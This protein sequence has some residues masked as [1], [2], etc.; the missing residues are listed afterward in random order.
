MPIFY[1]IWRFLC[2]HKTYSIVGI[3]YFF[4]YG[5]NSRSYVSRGESMTKLFRYPLTIIKDILQWRF[6][7]TQILGDFGNGLSRCI[8]WPIGHTD[9]DNKRGPN[10]IKNKRIVALTYHLVTT[11]SKAVVAKGTVCSQTALWPLP[12]S[13]CTRCI[14]NVSYLCT[15]KIVPCVGYRY[16]TRLRQWDMAVQIKKGDYYRRDLEKLRH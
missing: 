9:R 13:L 8:K 11:M 7:H 4:L 16:E 2:I 12:L 1:N 15:D 3:S 6:T 10:H 5:Q 14:W